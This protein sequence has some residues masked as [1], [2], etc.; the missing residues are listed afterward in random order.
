MTIE[1]DEK[2]KY[3][4]NIVTKAAIPAKIKTQTNLV[5]GDIHIKPDE[6]LKD[7]LDLP[8][9][10]LAVTNATVYT[11]AGQIAFQTSFLAIRREQIVWVTALSDVSKEE[12]P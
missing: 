1:Y 8:E 2:G 4:T 7:E 10:F 9:P 5:E 11:E 6:R 3:F 12:T